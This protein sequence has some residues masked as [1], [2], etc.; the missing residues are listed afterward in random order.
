M[1]LWNYN[2]IYRTDD[3]SSINSSFIRIISYNVLDSKENM[4]NINMQF[5]IYKDK[6]KWLSD[7][8]TN[9]LII[10][11]IGN[12]NKLNVVYNRS[13]DGVDIMYVLYEKL[14]KNLLTKFPQWDPSLLSFE[15]TPPIIDVSIN[16]ID[17][18][19]FTPPIIDVSINI[20][21]PS[22]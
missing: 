16:I 19:L 9:A 21:D 13:I 3:D 11:N 10:K 7:W 12:N 14:I 18:S 1:A 8:R 15:L 4:S 6:E 17:P 22:I 20:I 2:T 5:A